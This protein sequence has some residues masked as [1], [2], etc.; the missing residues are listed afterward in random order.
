MTGQPRRLAAPVPHHERGNGG[1]LSSAESIAERRHAAAAAVD[2]DERA[3]VGHVGVVQVRPESAVGVCGCECMTATAAGR[4][5]RPL[6]GGRV[7]RREH[8]NGGAAAAAGRATARS[9]ERAAGEDDA[10]PRSGGT[11]MIL[12]REQHA[13]QGRR[14]AQIP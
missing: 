6:S 7:A 13:T 3:A 8:V 5:E 1:D 11:V 4:G 12:A 9:G 2:L 10:V 14:E